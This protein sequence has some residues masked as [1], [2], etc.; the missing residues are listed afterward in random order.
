MRDPPLRVRGG[1]FSCHSPSSLEGGSSSS[2][3][4]I[5]DAEDFIQFEGL[6]SVNSAVGKFPYLRDF[7][8]YLSLINF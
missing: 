6:Y 3:E 5:E 2:A 4:I 7:L 8:N 1:E